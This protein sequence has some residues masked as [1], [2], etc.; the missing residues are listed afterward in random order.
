MEEEPS[1]VLESISGDSVFLGVTP[2]VHLLIA[3][4]RGNVDL[5]LDA[6]KKEKFEMTHNSV[7]TKSTFL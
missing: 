2:F 5:P 3:R 4:T 6:I 1:L 7:R